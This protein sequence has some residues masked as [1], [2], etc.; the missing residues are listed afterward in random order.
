MDGVVI[1]L[2][3]GLVIVGVGFAAVRSRERTTARDV[4]ALPVDPD[5]VEAVVGLLL[6]GRKIQAIKALREATGLGLA[7]AKALTE[8]IQRGHRPTATAATAGATATADAGTRADVDATQPGHRPE[9]SE[10]GLAD[11][12]RAL[13]ADGRETMAIRLVCDET[14]MDILDA[15]KFVRTL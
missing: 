1:F 11:R 10:P 6:R 4:L 7:E 9:V 3:V 12:A 13:R 15:Q 2:V 14:G 8:A 5:T